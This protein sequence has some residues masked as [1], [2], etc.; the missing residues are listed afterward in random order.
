MSDT[1][2]VD[3]IKAENLKETLSQIQTYLIWGIGSAL[4]FFILSSTNPTSTTIQV[5][6][7]GAFISVTPGLAETIALAI[8][9]ISGALASYAHERAQRIVLSLQHNREMLD[10][11]LLYPSIA[12]EIYSAVRVAPAFISAVLLITGLISKW[13]SLQV[14]ILW[15][16]FVFLILLSPYLYLII[17]LTYF[18]LPIKKP[19]RV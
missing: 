10:A 1:S 5:P 7:P 14:E 8:C 18:S 15:R 11:L 9:W 19:I 6:L 2:E 13:T 12:T 17:Q 3:K 16:V 4:S